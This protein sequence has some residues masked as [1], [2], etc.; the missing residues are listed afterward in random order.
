MAAYRTTTNLDKNE[1]ASGTADE[2][3]VLRLILGY[4]TEAEEARK[5]GPDG[6]GAVWQANGDLC[7]GRV[8]F[9]KTGEGQARVGMPEDHVLVG[10]WA[11]DV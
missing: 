9:S 6:R 11:G 10:S 3:D 1:P 7:V 2:A 5:G 8:D 4:K